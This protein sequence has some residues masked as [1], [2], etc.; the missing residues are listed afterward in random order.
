MSVTLCPS[1]KHLK[2]SSQMM[3]L[4]FVPSLQLFVDSVYLWNQIKVFF[5]CFY[6]CLTVMQYKHQPAEKPSE[7]CLLTVIKYQKKKKTEVPAVGK[8]MAALWESE[9]EKNDENSA[10]V[11]EFELNKKWG[12]VEA[13]P[14]KIANPD[15]ICAYF[16]LACLQAQSWVSLALSSYL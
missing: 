14:D 5:F 12:Q 3:T 4:Q 15:H 16:L 2:Y 7:T 6:Q 10:V 13:L 1:I 9:L 11:R 8:T